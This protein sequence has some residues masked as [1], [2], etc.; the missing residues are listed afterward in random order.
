VGR[1]LRNSPISRRR[2]LGVGEFDWLAL[3]LD[4]QPI[5]VEVRLA[6]LDDQAGANGEAPEDLIHGIECRIPTMS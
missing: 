5:G 3:N 4:H 1:T 2:T 6:R